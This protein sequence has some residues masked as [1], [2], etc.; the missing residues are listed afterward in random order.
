MADDGTCASVNCDR[1]PGDAYVCTLCGSQT[2]V[3]LREVP[4]LVPEL[5]TTLAREHRLGGAE[6]DSRA[7]NAEV[8]VP[9]HQ[10]ASQALVTL[11]GTLLSWASVTYRQFGTPLPH[12]DFRSSLTNTEIASHADY[13]ATHADR[14]RHHP[15]AGEFVDT[16]EIVID[17]A[18]HTVD[19]SPEMRY[20][21]PCHECGSDL[22]AHPKNAKVK[23]RGCGAMYDAEQRREWLRE[24]V[25]DRL[26]TAVEASRALPALL[27]KKLSVDTVRSWIAR[28]NI[29]VK[30][31]LH[32]DQVVI[33]KQDARDRPLCR[34]GDLITQALR[35]RHEKTAG[36]SEGN[37]T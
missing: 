17:R 6:N 18:W 10:G 13:L 9:F 24:Q 35:S 12:T 33:Q 1:P 22:Y 8:P 2:A 21:G 37:R 29:P 11:R 34:A 27:E 15:D 19:R 3:T 14:M 4:E 5:H 25:E 20:A 16:I 32:G 30:A 26:I 36:R 7:R 28:G 23:C 31:F